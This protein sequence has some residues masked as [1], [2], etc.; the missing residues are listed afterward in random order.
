[1][2]IK[3]ACSS[4][5]VPGHRAWSELAA[6]YELSFGDYGDWS[7]S[8]L[9]TQSEDI[10]VA[11][12]FLDDMQCSQD[13]DRDSTQELFV[14]FLGLL[15]RRLADSNAPTVVGFFSGES[16]SSIRRSRKIDT[17]VH[18]HYWCM[19]ELEKLAVK[20]DHF[21][22]IDLDKEFANIGY[23][24]ALDQRNWYFAHCHLS[25]AGLKCVASA[26]DRTLTR[27]SEA[28]S[29]LL[30]LDCDNTIWGGVVGEDGPDG[31]VLGL[32]GE[33]QAFADFQSAAKN[34]ARE[35]VLLALASK[36]NEQ[37]VLNVLQD[38]NA[39]VLKES[40]FA[41]WK[42]NWNQKA[43]N[44]E[45]L[46][47]ELDLGLSSF[48]FWDDNPDER[49]RMRTFL[50]EVYT[51]E[52]PESVFDWPKYLLNLDCFAK[53]SVTEEDKRKTEQYK[54]RARFVQE[55]ENVM[56][57]SAYLKSIKLKPYATA[58]G[59][60]NIARAEQLCLKTNQFNLRTMRHTTT[61][62]NSLAAASSDF[63]FLTSLKDLYGDHGVV[64][65]VCLSEIN[66]NLVFLDTLLMSCRVLG[67]HLETWMLNEALKRAHRSGH[68]YIVGEY[69]ETDKNAVAKDCLLSCGFKRLSNTSEIEFPPSA[70]FCADHREIY[71]CQTNEIKLPFMEVYDE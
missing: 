39:M 54:S 59:S 68:K 3:I 42:I 43:Q 2:K 36:N 15:E 41:A 25:S 60:N 40:D 53:F 16:A 24:Q 65:L 20:Y 69:I 44:V 66:P 9:G 27:Y 7:G 56:D 58:L 5:L 17:P 1:M 47:S 29:K 12:L 71:F 30:I 8:F 4:F 46:A 38:H 23:Q 49:E 22:F 50:P 57:E 70:D 55:R 13:S 31:I 26:V 10:V 19:T 32:D 37:D 64:G 14:P 34:L 35:G 52:P 67:R 28:P 6:K 18:V 45:A 11:V 61:E 21:F 62:L 51:V 48:V 33:G 63:C